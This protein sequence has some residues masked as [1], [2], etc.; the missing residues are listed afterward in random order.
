MPELCGWP[1]HNV[2]I[3][4][5]KTSELSNDFNDGT[6]TDHDSEDDNYEHHITVSTAITPVWVLNLTV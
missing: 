5:G 3:N 4:S 1:G 6:I 2:I